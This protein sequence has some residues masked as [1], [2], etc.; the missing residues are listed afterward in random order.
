MRL[1]IVAATGGVGRLALERARVGGH[2]VTAVVRNVTA[3][4]AGVPAVRVDLA[5]PDPGVLAGA[6]TGADAVVSALGARGRADTGIAERG[7]RALIAAMRAAGTSRLVCVSAAPVS[8]VASPGQPHPPRH[9]PGDDL[10]GRWVLTP[11]V[12]RIFRDAYADL[13][14]MED[15]LRESGLDWTVVRPPRLTGGPATGRYATAL[16]RSVRG[17][18][19]VSRADVADLLVTLAARPDTAG[20]AVGIAQTMRRSS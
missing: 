6:V 3:L 17:G 16:D 20:H 10:L 14:R 8:T 4:P 18:R 13:A 5:D 7:T 1:V 2:A 19:S 12:R 15:A 11:V 9:D